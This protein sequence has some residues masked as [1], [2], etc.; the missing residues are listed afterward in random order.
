MEISHE[1]LSVQER[2]VSSNGTQISKITWYKRVSNYFGNLCRLG[3]ETDG[4]FNPD[5]VDFETCF[6]LFHTKIE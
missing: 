1:D 2:D 6:G 4:T 3:Y 5:H